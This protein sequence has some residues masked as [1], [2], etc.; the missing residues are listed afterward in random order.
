MGFEEWWGANGKWYTD[1]ELHKEGFLAYPFKNG[2]NKGDIMVLR[3]V[4]PKAIKV[5]AVV[6]YEHSRYR[7]PIIHRVVAV[8]DDN[9]VRT[10]VTKGDNNYD[11]DSDPVTEEQIRRTGR[12]IL[13]VPLL[14][15]VKIWFVQ[16]MGVFSG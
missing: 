13:R 1:R 7:N 5:G 6:V 16:L 14:G 12:A 3:G 2:F 15:W 11:A 4:E 9:G 10:F 8:K